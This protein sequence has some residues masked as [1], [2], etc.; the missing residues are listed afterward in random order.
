MQSHSGIRS[1]KSA[2][3]SCVLFLVHVLYT[4]LLYAEAQS[5]LPKLAAPC[6]A[7]HS[8]V[9]DAATHVGP[10]L[11]G[12]AGRKLGADLNYTY[13][14]ALTAKASEGTVWDRA[15]LDSFLEKPQALIHGTTMSYTGV[16]DEAERKVLLDWLFSDSSVSVVDIENANF[17]SEPGVRKIVEYSA[18]IGYGEYLAG[19]CLTCHQASAV[20][21]QVPPIHKLTPDYFVYAML[22]YQNGVRSNSVMQSVA[23]ALGEEEIAALSAVFTQQ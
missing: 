22:E 1:S 3:L 8:L 10:S 16:A 14:E 17:L 20:N 7:C 4:H 12:L 6:L 15:T 9:P 19:E 11:S 21:G 2:S 18:D 23:G 5:T 13:S